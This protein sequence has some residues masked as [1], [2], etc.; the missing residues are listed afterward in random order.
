MRYQASGL[1][2]DQRRALDRIERTLL[3]DDRRLGSLFAT[4]T[5]LTSHEA[6]AQAERVAA[7]SWHQRRRVQAVTAL[8]IGLAALVGA[9]LTGLLAPS[10]QACPA[11]AAPAAAHTQPF[12]AGQRTPCPAR[13]PA[14]NSRA[15]L[16]YLR[17]LLFG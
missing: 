17:P 2:G 3:E 15:A 1:P 13:Q 5:Q 7:R 9:L 6:M 16:G 4:F 11:S 12:S 8:A 10:R 14:G